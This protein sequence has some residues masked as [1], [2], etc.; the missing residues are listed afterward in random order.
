MLGGIVN[1]RGKASVLSIGA[2]DDD[3]SPRLA[4]VFEETSESQLSGPN[5]MNK[6]NVNT[7]VA[8]TLDAVA[9]FWSSRGI[10]KAAKTLNYSNNNI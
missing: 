2:R 8:A 4:F 1:S 6:I 3:N 7:C 10:P 5:W 9:A